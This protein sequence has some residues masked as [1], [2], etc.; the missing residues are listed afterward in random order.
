MSTAASERTP[1]L[2]LD[3]PNPQFCLVVGLYVALLAVPIVLYGATNVG[4]SDPAALDGVFLASGVLV[5]AVTWGV[6]RLDGAAQRS[7]TARGRR[8]YPWD[9]FTGYTR[10][11]DAI[12]CHRPRRVDVQFALTDLDDADAVE[13]ALRQYLDRTEVASV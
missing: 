1:P 5:A 12:V 2:P 13:R 11:D 3:S 8:L 4:V 9:A 6:G 10:T 7:G